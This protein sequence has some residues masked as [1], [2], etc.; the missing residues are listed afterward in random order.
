M[1]ASLSIHNIGYHYPDSLWRLSGINLDIAAGQIT[2][3]VGPN[4]SGKS[5]LLKVAAGIISPDE[6]KVLLGKKPIAQLSRRTIAQNLGYLPQQVTSTFDYIVSEVVAMGR[7][8]HTS[9]MTFLSGNDV[10]IVDQC[11]QQTG[12]FDFRSRR[13]S[14]LSGGERQRVMLASVLAQQPNILL[15]DEPTTG[16]DIHHQV[17]FFNLIKD[18]AKEGLAIAVVTHDL[19]LASLFCDQ[20]LLLNQ[21]SRVKYGPPKEVITKEVLSG[22]Y[23]GNIFI[24]RFPWVDKPMVLPTDWVDV[25]EGR[26]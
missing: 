10:E 26:Q 8:A 5:T 4:G 25:S 2:G 6:G 21:G 9:A 23:P 22:I 12:T 24:S 15:L 20:L 11:L 19:N 13:L 3:I 14:H 17:T 7:F 18:L 1:Q 16:L